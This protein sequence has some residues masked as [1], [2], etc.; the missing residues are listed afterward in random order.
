LSS[1]NIG[2]YLWGLLS[3]WSV[4]TSFSSLTFTTLVSKFITRTPW[5]MALCMPF[6]L[7]VPKKMLSKHSN[8]GQSNGGA[9][10]I[11]IFF[12]FVS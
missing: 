9:L 5:S 4:W 11:S 6:I 8:H 2:V 1:P 3:I 7:A 10:V 12:F